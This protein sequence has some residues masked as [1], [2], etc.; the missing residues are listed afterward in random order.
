MREVCHVLEVCN[1]HAV[2]ATQKGFAALVGVHAYTFCIALK[3]LLS[4]AR[5]PVDN[6]ASTP[7]RYGRDDTIETW[8]ES[9]LGHSRLET[10]P[11]KAD[12]TPSLNRPLQLDST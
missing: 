7:R 8:V 6:I 11:T 3:L 1:L 9:Q 12:S 4:A 2:Q 10:K 5:I